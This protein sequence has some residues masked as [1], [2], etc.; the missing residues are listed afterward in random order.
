M[1]FVYV[2]S[3]KYLKVSGSLGFVITQT[4][5]KTKGAADGFRRFRFNDGKEKYVLKPLMVDD[6][7]RV[8]VFEGATNRTSVLIC[9][10]TRT[11]FDYPVAYVQWS[12]PSRISQDESLSSVLESVSRESGAA[13]PIQSDKPTSPWL[14]APP[15]VLAA[16]QK[17]IGKSEYKAWEGANTGGLNGVYWVQVL[18]QLNEEELLIE[19]LW[20]VGKIKVEPLKKAV[21]SGLVYPLLRGRDVQRWRVE[22]SASILLVQ[23]PKT[24]IGIPESTMKKNYPKTYSYLKHFEPELRRRSGYRS[25][26]EPSD[27]FWSM[28][29][30]GPY[31]MSP[32]KVVWREQ[33]SELQAAAVAE[34]SGKPVIPDHKLMMVECLSTAEAHYLAGA[35]NSRPCRLAV[36]SYVLSTSTSTHVLEHINVPTFNRQNKLHENISKLSASCHSA[37]IASDY[38]RVQQLENEIDRMSAEL[39][40]LTAAESAAIVRALQSE[41]EP[42]DLDTIEE[43]ENAPAVRSKTKSRN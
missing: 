43:E 29:N 25:Y 41:T 5:F 15:A 1:L 20:D 37:A 13:L 7:S 8:Q 21:E 32:A 39:W 9:E 42:P 19:N 38:E 26:F 31:T 40:G 10:K 3:D 14:T 2:S 6:L 4:V 27:P 16:V 28:Y 17:V 23:D 24:R 35:L 12:G 30:I 18:R 22:P 11:D 36:R 34:N 33:S